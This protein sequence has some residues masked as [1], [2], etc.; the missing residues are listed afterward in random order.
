MFSPRGTEL[1]ALWTLAS[2]AALLVIGVAVAIRRSYFNAG[3]WFLVILC[4]LY[5]RLVW[6]VHFDRP[7]PIPSHQG[8]VIVAN[9]TC[10]VDPWFMQ[11]AVDRVVHWMVASEYFHHPAMLWFFR[12][13]KSI[14]VKRGGVDT[15][16]TKQAIRYAKQGGLVGNFPEGR[17]N[18]TRALLLP[19]RPGAA[20]IALKARVPVLPCYVFDAPFSTSIPGTFLQRSKTRIVV[21]ELIDISEYYGRERESG[22]LQ[23]LTLGFMKEIAKLSGNPD[24]EPR[25]AGRRW[26]P[27]EDD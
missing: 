23:E 13:A 20:L 25:L 7:M 12:I 16:A 27:E 10:G 26:K 18:I 5:S 1:L 2:L 24:F 14:P 19:G 9:H 17:I 8:A 22:V 11:L 6:R 21:G 4:K 3:Q 15:S